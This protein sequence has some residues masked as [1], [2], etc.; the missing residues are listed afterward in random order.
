MDPKRL[1]HIPKPAMPLP[2]VITIALRIVAI[3]SPLVWIMIATV[4]AVY[5]GYS[6]T[7]LT[8]PGHKRIKVYD[9]MV[10]FTTIVL[11]VVAF[12]YTYNYD[13]NAFLWEVN[14]NVDRAIFGAQ[15]SGWVNFII[16]YTLSTMLYLYDKYREKIIRDINVSHKVW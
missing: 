15:F 12:A 4:R 6:V 14:T 8:D 9:W 16:L 3:V 7:Y 10:V 11:T 5:S 2:K 13:L 1:A